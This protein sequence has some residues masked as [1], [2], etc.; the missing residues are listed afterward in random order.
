MAGLPSLASLAQLVARMGNPTLSED[1]QARAQ[2]DLD[3]ASALIRAEVK[4]T[5]WAI[6]DPE[7]DEAWVLDDVPAVVETVTLAVARR[8][9]D[10][11]AGV[12][13]KSVGDV[14]ITYGADARRGGIYLTKDE[15]RLVRRAAELS[16]M[17]SVTLTSA[18]SLLTTVYIPTDTPDADPIPMGGGWPWES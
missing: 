17:G 9:F 11:P 16:S 15:R 13:Q 7:D 1:E 3:D 10:N 6:V 8:S 4:P 18:D 2:A 14:S 12:A 5:T